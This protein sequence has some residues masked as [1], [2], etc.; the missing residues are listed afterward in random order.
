M[1]GATTLTLSNP[2]GAAFPPSG[3]I[4]QVLALSAN[5]PAVQPLTPPINYDLDTD[6][7][8]LNLQTPLP[9]P[10]T[11]P[12]A[13]QVAITVVGSLPATSNNTPVDATSDQLGVNPEFTLQPVYDPVNGPLASAVYPFSLPF[14]RPLETRAALPEEPEQL[15]ARAMQTFQANGKPTDLAIACEYLHLSPEELALL[16]G[17]GPQGQSS[18]SLAEFYGYPPGTPEATLILPTNPIS[19]NSADVTLNLG[20]VQNFMSATGLGFSDVVNLLETRFVNPNQQVTLYSPSSVTVTGT[21]SPGQ[22]TVT[23]LVDPCDLTYLTFQGLY[24]DGSGPV[25]GGLPGLWMFSSGFLRRAILFLRLWKKT[26]WTMDEL[27]K[28]F[29]ALGFSEGFPEMPLSGGSTPATPPLVGPI[30]GLVQNLAGVKWLQQTLNVSVTQVLSLGSTIDTA[31]RDSLYNSLFQNKAVLNPVDPAFALQCACS[32]PPG[33]GGTAASSLGFLAPYAAAI[34]YSNGQLN[35]TGTASLSD[36]SPNGP[37]TLNQLALLLSLSDDAA[38]GQAVQNL[39]AGQSPQTVSLP[40]GLNLPSYLPDA[41]YCT[42]QQSSGLGGIGLASRKPSRTQ[43]TVVGAMAKEFRDWLLGLQASAPPPGYQLAIENLYEMRWLDSA[44]VAAGAP[45][46]SHLN[47]ILAALQIGA[48]DLQAI[49][50]DSGLIPPGG[51]L[52]A[53]AWLGVGGVV[54]PGDSVTVTVG[55]A[56]QGGLH[57]P[58]GVPITHVVVQG[59][60]WE[61]IAAALAARINTTPGLPGGVSARAQAAVINLYATGSAVITPGSGVSETLNLITPP[62]LTLANL[63]TLYRYALL[64][65]ALN[66]SVPDLIGLK[67]LTGLNPF[68]PNATTPV[69]APLVQFVKAAQMVAASNFSIA[70]L[71]YL[72][73]AQPDAVDNLPPLPATAKQ[74][75]AGLAAGLQKIAAANAFAPDPKGVALRKKLAAQLPANAVQPAM[76]LI[77][78]SALYTTPLASLPAALTASRPA[79]AGVPFLTTLV[80]LGG[81]VSI[82]DSLELVFTSTGVQGAPVSLPSPQVHSCPRGDQHADAREHRHHPGGGD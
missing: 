74:L 64:A 57:L 17:P 67:A 12:T 25:P 29:T 76:D 10:L 49:A 18:A 16:A 53:F 35:F 42:P 19:S 54:T 46:S 15:P 68:T 2:A 52:N 13:V 37:M 32:V 56:P 36:G 5:P 48:S 7:V 39:F 47:T 51:D 45:I 73:R 66:I 55:F 24:T 8:T 21:G 71:N 34:T 62:P 59:D 61:S 65:Q 27:D 82:G 79:A 1:A 20:L 4:T 44:D 77:T 22:P 60:T 58:A 38:Y 81:T 63:S 6:N 80:T 3:T 30:E 11:L 72:Y 75:L 40:A 78:G 43:L 28:V 69:T 50:V 33:S 9:S 26:G 41:I 31:G 70:Q 14:N 23:Q